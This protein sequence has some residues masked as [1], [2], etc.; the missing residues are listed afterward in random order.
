MPLFAKR[1]CS[2]G[3]WEGKRML[4]VS[5]FFAD[6]EDLLSRNTVCVVLNM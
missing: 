2:D 3:A 4:R 6:R 1:R 5:S